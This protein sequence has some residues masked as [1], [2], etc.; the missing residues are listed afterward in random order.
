[1]HETGQGDEGGLKRACASHPLQSGRLLVLE[2]W[3]TVSTFRLEMADAPHSLIFVVLCSVYLRLSKTARTT[4]SPALTHLTESRE[5]IAD[6]AH[7]L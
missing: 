1:M 3:R 6:S 5:A 7:A 2:A 4:G